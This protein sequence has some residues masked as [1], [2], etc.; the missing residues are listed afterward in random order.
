MAKSIVGSVLL[1]LLCTQAAI[2]AESERKPLMVFGAASLTDVLQAVSDEYTKSSGIAVKL[3]FAASSVLAK[4]IESGARADVFVSADQEWMSY[5]DE[6]RL[7]DKSTR[8][9]L[10]GNK[11]VLI[12]PRQ[13]SVNM[14][15]VRHAPLL[16]ALG[17]DGRLATGDPDSVPVG[18]YAKAALISL[19]IWDALQ[20][21]LA[22]ADNVRVALMYVARGEAPLGIV[23]ATDAAA[24][25]KI[26]VVD[27]FPA[28]SHPPITYPVATTS[29]AQ[30]AARAYVDFLKAAS[31]RAL[32]E[33]AGFTTIAA[34]SGN[35]CDDFRF[36]ASREL[37][38]AQKT[39]I[40]SREP[41]LAIPNGRRVGSRRTETL[42]GRVAACR[43]CALELN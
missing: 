43:P 10:L 35:D 29:I 15:L 22:R 7:I 39:A 28:S 3:S 6:R 21:R 4:Q 34:R 18:K 31:A 24:E 26:R 11:L 23:Y 38:R 19:D 40:K 13:S 14:K 41:H 42:P 27:T 25:P 36:D 9:D 1:A 16:A 8:S 5:L 33:K 12:A 30:P 17:N 32:F 37:L 20:S 2:A